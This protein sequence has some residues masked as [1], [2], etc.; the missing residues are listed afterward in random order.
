MLRLRNI[1]IAQ[2]K[3]KSVF[4]VRGRRVDPAKMD[5]FAR[6]KRYLE[7]QISRMCT[8]TAF[9]RLSSIALTTLR[10]TT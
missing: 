8:K 6:R 3:K 4:Y 5:R 10:R 9:L 2:G 7:S 1:R